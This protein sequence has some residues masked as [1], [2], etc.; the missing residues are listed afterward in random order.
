MVNNNGYCVP[1]VVV[2][3]LVFVALAYFAQ[4][5]DTLPGEI[6]LSIWVQSWQT[7]WI[8]DIARLTKPLGMPIVYG[9]LVITTC[10]ALYMKKCYLESVFLFAITITGVLI[11]IP[12]ENLVASPPPNLLDIQAFQETDQNSFPSDHATL[13]TTFLGSLFVI[14]STNLKK[15]WTRYIVQT[16]LIMILIIIGLSRVYIGVHWLSDILAGFILGIILIVAGMLIR[17]RYLHK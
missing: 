17:F 14:L 3:S 12:I 6:R 10:A 8:D 9:G 4:G 1:I 13:Y 5:P 7:H 16:T 15:E 11:L 2:L